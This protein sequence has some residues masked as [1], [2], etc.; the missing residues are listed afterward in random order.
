MRGFQ[1]EILRFWT[2]IIGQER[3]PDVSPTAQNLGGGNCPL[4]SFLP[5]T[6]LL[7]SLTYFHA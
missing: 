4:S 3:Y 6:M 5:A 1:P 7:R 2:K